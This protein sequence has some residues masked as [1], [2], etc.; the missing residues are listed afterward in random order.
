MYKRMYENKQIHPKFHFLAKIEIKMT[1]L[2]FFLL[3]LTVSSPLKPF[4]SC[5]IDYYNLELYRTVR[6]LLVQLKIVIASY[7]Y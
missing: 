7:L 1:Y 3:F 6:E 2:V 5:F 4:G